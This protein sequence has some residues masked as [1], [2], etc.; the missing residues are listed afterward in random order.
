MAFS[1]SVWKKRL[2]H[3]VL[4]ALI[5][6]YRQGRLHG[7]I[8]LETQMKNVVQGQSGVAAA[9]EPEFGYHHLLGASK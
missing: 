9:Q 4:R 5:Y 1:K 6:G 7:D 2:N 3:K 8:L